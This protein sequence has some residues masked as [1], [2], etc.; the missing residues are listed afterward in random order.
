MEWLEWSACSTIKNKEQG[1]NWAEPPKVLEKEEVA[2]DPDGDRHASMTVSFQF[3][4]DKAIAAILHLASKP[5]SVPTLDKYKAAKLIFFADKYHLVRNGRPI[6]GDSYHALEHGP[7]PQ[8]TL[9]LLHMAIG[10]APMRGP[11]AFKLANSVSVDRTHRY[12]RIAATVPPRLDFLSVSE[13]RALDHVIALYGTRSFLELRVLTHATPAYKK[14]WEN[15]PPGA[16]IALM[17]YED[18]FEE[19]PD[20]IAGALEEMLENDALRKAY[21]AIKK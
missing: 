1:M 4:A 6:T 12:P 17:Q 10:D 19:D 18:F 11:D 20:A 14:A 9:D 13:L 5:E 7:V 2:M 21:P 3:E 8:Q 15:R 16:E